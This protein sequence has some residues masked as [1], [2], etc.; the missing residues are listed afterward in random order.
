MMGTA[1]HHVKE[2]CRSLAAVPGPPFGNFSLILFC[3]L[4]VLSDYIFLYQGISALLFAWKR[5][6]RVGSPEMGP[7]G[8]AMVAI[9]PALNP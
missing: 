3:L 7:W 5:S 8:D 9:F 4:T 1:P 6:N 2:P